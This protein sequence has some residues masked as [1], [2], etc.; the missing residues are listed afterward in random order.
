M[1]GVMH[2]ASIA[3][4]LRESEMEQISNLKTSYAIIAI[5]FA[6]FA[7]EFLFRGM[8]FRALDRE[9]GGWRAILG[10]AVFFASYHPVAAWLPVGVLG[11]VNA[12]LFKKTGWLPA[13][14][15]AHTF[16]N[17]VVVLM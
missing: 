12:V 13:A 7:E 5:A 10:S 14:V 11:A 4:P 8:L 17:A 6:P 1:W 15:A 9:W 16:Y 2:I 3:Q